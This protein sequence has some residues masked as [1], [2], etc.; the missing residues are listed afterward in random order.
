M[1]LYHTCRDVSAAGGTRGASVHGETVLNEPAGAG[2]DESGLASGG[3]EEEEE[4][5]SPT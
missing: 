2:A 4:E 5:G 1:A 3:L